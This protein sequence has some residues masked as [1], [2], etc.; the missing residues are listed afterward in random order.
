MSFFN[1]KPVEIYTADKAVS[2]ANPLP[3]TATGTVTVSVVGQLINF[4]WDYVA[5]NYPSDTQEVY[6]FRSGGSG[7]AAVGTVT[8][9]YTDNTK[10]NLSSATKT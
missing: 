7:G 8:L 2:P 1:G 5:V 9:E 6:T 10:A 3:V 4:N